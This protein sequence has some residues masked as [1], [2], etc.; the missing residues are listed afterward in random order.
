MVAGVLIHSTA[1]LGCDSPEGLRDWCGVVAHQIGE[2]LPQQSGAPPGVVVG[3]S[4]VHVV[5]N[6]RRS[7]AVVQQVEQRAIGAINRLQCSL[8]PRPRFTGEMRDV[9]IG[10]LQPGVSGEP[11]VDP[12]SYTH[13]TLPTKA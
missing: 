9:L 2:L 10:M 13:L 1:T 5:A 8:G 11:H 12:V 7:N 3:N 6:V 4:G